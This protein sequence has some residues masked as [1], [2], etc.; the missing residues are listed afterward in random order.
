M[1]VKSTSVSLMLL[2]LVYLSRVS[3]SGLGHLS[4]SLVHKNELLC[5]VLCLV[6]VC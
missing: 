4:L 5:A 3:S 1:R 2:S 6:F